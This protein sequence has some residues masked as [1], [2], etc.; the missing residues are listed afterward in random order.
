MIDDME[1]EAADFIAQ[2]RG[3]VAR[4]A[5]QDL[6]RTSMEELPDLL[7]RLAGKLGVFG[8]DS[9]GDAARLLMLELRNGLDVSVVTER[10]SGIVV[11]L[12]SA[13]ERST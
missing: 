9:A 13:M 11:Q 4:T 8:Y 1:P 3:T 7:H 10:V 2:R 12:E 5:V 6:H